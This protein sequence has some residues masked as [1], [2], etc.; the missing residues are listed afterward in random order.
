MEFTFGQCPLLQQHNY[1]HVLHQESGRWGR[2]MLLYFSFSLFRDTGIFCVQKGGVQG[3]FHK[4]SAR[5][6]MA[7]TKGIISMFPMYR[8][9]LPPYRM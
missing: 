9:S 7:S 5:F 2:L 4:I 8:F 6:L 1:W 3:G